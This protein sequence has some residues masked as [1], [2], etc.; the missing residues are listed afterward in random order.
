MIV[1]AGAAVAA[2][3]LHRNGHTQ[4]DDF[5]LYLRQ[6]RSLFDGDIGQ[7]VADNRFT[8]INSGGA[9]SPTAYPW[10]WPLLLSPFVHL[11][12]LDYD[13]LKLVEVAAFCVW[14]VLVHGIIRRRAGRLLALAIVAVV[15]T[16][17]LL[18]AHTDQLLSEYPHAAAV[19]AFIWWMDRIKTRRPLIGATTRELAVLGVLAAA[20][21]NVRRESVI[22]VAVVLVVQMAELLATRRGRPPVPVPW[23]TVA[24]PYAAFVVAVVGFQLLLPSMLVPDNGDGPR[25]VFARLGDYTGV[26]TQQLGLGSHPALGVFILLLAGAG[27]VIGCI[28]RPRLDVPLAAVTVLSG[29]AVSTHFRM[30]GRYYFQI[31]PWVLYFAAAAVVACVSLIVRPRRLAAVVAA[32]PMLYLVTVHLAVLPGDIADARDFNAAGRQQVGPT[33]P[34]ITPIFD[35]VERYTAPTDVITYFRA[36]T[37]TLYTDR[38]AIQTT[39]MDRVLQRSDY[40]AQMRFSDYYQPDITEDEAEEL[41]LV[42]VW[43]DRKWILW[44]LPEPD[45]D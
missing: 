29:L 42:E 41:G 6:A 10:G 3:L 30:V 36:R 34:T 32:V 11:W 13:R 21:Y 9:F 19:A 31:T 24:T 44:R 7:V 20:A 37:M 26:L 4:G 22:L 28:R 8:V 16:A 38:L 39:N 2:V 17:P 18:L 43:S 33:D 1:V 35:A 23:R 27:M 14:L 40:F 45:G 25:Y 5:A 15:G 12:G